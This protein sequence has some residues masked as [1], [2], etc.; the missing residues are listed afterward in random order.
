MTPYQLGISLR[1]ELLAL[2]QRQGSL[3]SRNL[4]AL[5]ADLAG[6]GGELMPAL[7]Q[8]MI[9]PAL[10]RALNQPQPLSDPRDRDRLQAEIDAVYALPIR[11]SMDEL[12]Q[13]L[14]NQQVTNPGPSAEGAGTSREASPRWPQSIHVTGQAGS[15][16]SHAAVPALLALIAGMMLMG[17]A[18]LVFALLQPRQSSPQQRAVTPVPAQ[19]TPPVA[20][21]KPAARI[22]PDPIAKQSSAVIDATGSIDAAVTSIQ[23]LY[24]ALS[25]KDFSGSN[26][27]FS[28][29]VGDQFDPTF[30]RQFERVSIS[31]LHATSTA[32]STVNLDGTVSFIYPD[33]SIQTESRS[34]SVDTSQSPGLITGSEFGRVIKAR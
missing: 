18:G 28:S 14:F 9:S 10:L 23:L 22:E 15:G 19:P 20:A 8:M 6:G 11:T 27:Y 33:G 12:L 13:G 2:W 25:N 17:L 1:R 29:A 7:R 16:T 3:D 34:F 32:G 4:Q 21:P 26:Q 5:I 24:G 30:F 31:D